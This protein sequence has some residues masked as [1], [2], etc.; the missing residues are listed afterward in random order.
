MVT[1]AQA[2]SGRERLGLRAPSDY[3]DEHWPAQ[4]KVLA[5]GIDIDFVYDSISE[6]HRVKRASSTLPPGGDVVIV[7]SK[8]GGAFDI[9]GLE[10]LQ[11]LMERYGRA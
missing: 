3:Q 11:L 4:I 9:V 1:A 8:E 2:L 6:E 5:G 7:R 10:R